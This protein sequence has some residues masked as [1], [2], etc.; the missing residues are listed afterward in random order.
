MKKTFWRPAVSR[1]WVVPI[2]AL[3]FTLSIGS[4]A[5]AV[6]GTGADSAAALALRAHASLASTDAATATTL[7]EAD[8]LALDQAKENAILDLIR[9]KMSPA[10]QEI[11]DEL[12][13]S[14]GTQQLE[15]QQAQAA[16]DATTAQISE[17]VDKYLGI[18]TTTTFAEDTYAGGFED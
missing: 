1:K 12:R 15:L 18:T 3:V 14:A 17:L 8:A 13:A 2:A 7:S 10:D 5:F 11:L 9:Q 4:V 6:G 16:L